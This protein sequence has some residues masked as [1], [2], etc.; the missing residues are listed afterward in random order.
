MFNVFFNLISTFPLLVTES[1]ILPQQPHQLQCHLFFWGTFKPLAVPFAEG[2]IVLKGKQQQRSRSTNVAQTLVTSCAEFPKH[3]LSVRK[4]F[5]LHFLRARV[6]VFVFNSVCNMPPEKKKV[7]DE[8]RYVRYDLRHL[9]TYQRNSSNSRTGTCEL[10]QV[11]RH[12]KQAVM[13]AYLQLFPNLSN[14]IRIS[15]FIFRTSTPSTQQWI[16]KSLRAGKE[17]NVFFELEKSHHSNRSLLKIK[18]R[19][20][21]PPVWP[22]SI[23]SCMI[24]M[25]F[26]CPETGQC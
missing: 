4:Y 21:F 6:C 1:E 20:I 11:L 8:H 10:V 19:F 22:R 18:E 5:F 2:E 26:C 3:L 16:S 23:P 25:T 7:P 12:H 9:G 15:R 24:G 13:K 17:R 14:G